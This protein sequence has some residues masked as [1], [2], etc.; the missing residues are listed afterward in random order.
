MGMEN[1]RLIKKVLFFDALEGMRKSGRPLLS[2][3]QSITQDIKNFKVQDIMFADDYPC[4]TVRGQS[5]LVKAFWLTDEEWK[6]DFRKT[7]DA[8]HSDFKLVLI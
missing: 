2:Q 3:S 8:K 6:D 7:R 5:R 1:D 4:N